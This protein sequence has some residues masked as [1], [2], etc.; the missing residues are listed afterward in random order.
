MEG[1]D[2]MDGE[3]GS[4]ILR[5]VVQLPLRVN[6]RS[7]FDS[8]SSVSDSEDEI[9]EAISSHIVNATPRKYRRILPKTQ[10]SAVS[11]FRHG[12]VTDTSQIKSRSLIQKKQHHQLRSSQRLSSPAK[13]RRPTPEDIELSNR[14]SH[15]ASQL[16]PLISVR[17][18]LP[19]PLFPRS[20]LQYH[21]LTHDQLDALARH[22]HQTLDAGEERWM[23]PCPIPFGKSWC[24]SSPPAMSSHAT[25][26]LERRHLVDLETRRRRWGRFIGLKGCESPVV[27]GPQSV[28][29]AGETL[30]ERFEREWREALRRAEEEHKIREKLW[31][32]RF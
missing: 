15:L 30:M 10:L 1:L 6:T 11:S 18:G 3:L 25:N 20:L 26:E 2:K 16:V 9:V 4:P 14:I 13:S 5:R 31:G 19:H 29:E 24:G 7:S 28:R 12:A 17:T 22:Y 32:R 21:L 8:A 27:D 23:Y